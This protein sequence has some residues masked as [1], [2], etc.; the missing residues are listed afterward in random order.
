MITRKTSVFAGK[1]ARTEREREREREVGGRFEK[2]Q[3][4]HVVPRRYER[5]IKLSR[6][7]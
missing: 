4:K 3:S 7:G 2:F 1:Y 6:R 5:E